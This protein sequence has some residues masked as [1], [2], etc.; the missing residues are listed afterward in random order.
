MSEFSTDLEIVVAGCDGKILETNLKD[1]LP[2]Q[3]VF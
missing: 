1:L 2:N 3:F